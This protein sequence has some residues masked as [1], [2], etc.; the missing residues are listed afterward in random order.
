MVVRGMGRPPKY[1]QSIA[2]QG[3]DLVAAFAGSRPADHT[4]NK[5]V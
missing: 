1:L 4:G 2:G 5:F 3:E